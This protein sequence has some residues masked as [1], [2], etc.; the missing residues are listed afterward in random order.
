M[1]EKIT[2][3]FKD[4]LDR[5]WSEFAKLEHSQ[6]Y[7]SAQGVVFALIRACAKGKLPAIKEALDRIDGK[8][9]ME[10]EVEFPKF[11]FRFPYATG[12]AG[13]EGSVRDD[14][15]VEVLPVVKEEEE[16]VA[17]D[18][19]RSVLQRMSDEPRQLVTEILTTAAQIDE[20]VA[21]ANDLPPGDPKVVSVIVA[22]LL[23]MAHAGKLG[24]IF[25]VLDQIDGKVA[26]KLK[27]LGGDVIINRLDEIAPAGAVKNEEGIYQIEAPQTTSVWATA[28]ERKSKN[29]RRFG[30]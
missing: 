10:I 21:Y 2:P 17:T 23:D 7:T 25:E 22:G 27:V 5:P 16:P 6:G 12:V 13:I 18:S 8:V 24:A 1:A 9:A 26:D 19:I 30:R 4:L 3:F 28:L 11:Y 20:A 14:E 15:E 29:D